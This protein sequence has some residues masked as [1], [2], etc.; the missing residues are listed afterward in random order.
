MPFDAHEIVLRDKPAALLEVSPKGTV[1]VLVL[2]DGHVIEQSW[3]IV[4]WALTHSDQA[5]SIQAWWHHGQSDANTALVHSN[6]GAFK[7]HLDRYKYPERFSTEQHVTVNDLRAHHRAQA[8]QALLQPLE[9]RLADAAFLG[10][11]SPCATDIGIFP[12]VRQFAS[13]DPPW[14]DHQPLV[15][16]RRWLAHWLQ[17]PLFSACMAKLPANRPT[18]F[19]TPWF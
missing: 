14:F 16:V 12:F 18:R 13:I 19:G 8:V 17:S 7:H 2:T 10:G 1:P 4:R 6:D 3:D 11:A 9:V 15:Q 5:D